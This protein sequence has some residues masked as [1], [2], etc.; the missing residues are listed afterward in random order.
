MSEPAIVAVIA[1]SF[2]VGA[3][4]GAVTMAALAA[5]GYDKGH[6]DGVTAGEA[7][8][9]K[10]ARG[11]Y[12]NGYAMGVLV[13]GAQREEA[14]AIDDPIRAIRRELDKNRMLSGIVE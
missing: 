12:Y 7:A 9:R 5:A 4:L 2:L 6:A 3:F 8:Q 11:I 1:L 10:R 13:G 14:A